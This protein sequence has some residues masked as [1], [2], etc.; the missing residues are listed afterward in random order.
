MVNLRVQAPLSACSRRFSARRFGEALL[1]PLPGPALGIHIDVEPKQVDALNL[2]IMATGQRVVFTGGDRRII[3]SDIDSGEI[4]CTI[5]RDSGEIPLLY[6]LD[7]KIISASSNGSMRI[8]SINHTLSRTKVIKT[9]WE[10]S[11]CIR[12][13]LFSDPVPPIRGRTW[14]EMFGKADSNAWVLLIYLLL[15]TNEN[16][17]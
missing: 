1:M 7:E 8:F 5:T 6:E 17:H 2:V 11:R 9:T 14:A 16:H 4:I 12:G 10:H 3:A 13:L 15:S